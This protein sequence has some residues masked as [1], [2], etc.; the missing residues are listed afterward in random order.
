ME[1]SNAQRDHDSLAGCIN[2]LQKK[3]YDTDLEL[4]HRGLITRTRDTPLDP[5]LFTIDE[6]FRFEGSS[7]P[8]DM[9]I[10]YAISSEELGIK[11]LIVN[12]FGTYASTIVDK[13]VSKLDV[14]SNFSSDKTQPGNT[15]KLH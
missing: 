14:H 6:F 5:A 1:N 15:N 13:M 10:V 3:G 12:A 4:N 9:S 11:G 2:A 8:A 7:D